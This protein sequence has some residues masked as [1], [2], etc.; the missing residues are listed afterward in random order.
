MHVRVHEA[1]LPR[2]APQS[3][4][5]NPI[6]GQVSSRR[7]LGHDG[8]SGPSRTARRTD[9]DGGVEQLDQPVGRRVPGSADVVHWTVSGLGYALAFVVLGGG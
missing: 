3:K 4:H 2:P 6:W 1:N 8:W 5:P 7:H 9:Q